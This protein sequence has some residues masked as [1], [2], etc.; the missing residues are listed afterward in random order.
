MTHITCSYHHHHS[1]QV[2]RVPGRRT[3]WCTDGSISHTSGSASI[4][5]FSE[6]KI[7]YTHICIHAR[8]DAHELA[9]RSTNLCLIA[10]CIWFGGWPGLVIVHVSEWLSE[11]SLI[12]PINVLLEHT[13][14]RVRWINIC[15]IYSSVTKVNTSPILFFFL[16]T[17]EAISPMLHIHLCELWPLSH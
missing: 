12:N 2:T 14:S 7:R 13:C 15:F 1:I 3:S 4:Q 11:H 10:I 6:L 9:L 17:K 5:T 16:L 8:I